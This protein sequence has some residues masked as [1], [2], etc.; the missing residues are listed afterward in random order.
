MPRFRLAKRI[1]AL[2]F[3]VS[4]GSGA[5][6]V[7]LSQSNAP[8]AVL[9]AELIQ[10]F[11]GERAAYGAV[12]PDQFFRL[13]N[14]PERRSFFGKS[15][16]F[17]YSREYLT[18]L[19]TAKGDAQWHCLSEALYF[20]ARGESVMGQF[21]VAEV[22]MNRV[23]SSRFPSSLC[24]VIHQGTGQRFQCQFTYTCDGR[25]ENIGDRGAWNSVAKIARLMLDGKT[26]DLTNGATHYHT[27]SVNPRWARIFPRTATIGAHHFYRQPVR[28]A[29]NN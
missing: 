6:D 15:G 22:I 4:A 10:L 16:G 1:C 26:R 2:A 9:D 11:G 29:S 12:Q 3:L 28:T 5:A 19:P 13:Q 8:R 27:K 20:E 7:T 24:R 21:A 25:S 14:V 18:T 23:D 17:A